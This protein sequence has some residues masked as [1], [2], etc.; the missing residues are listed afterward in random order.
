MIDYNPLNFKIMKQ[1]ILIIGLMIST[2]GLT[3]VITENLFKG[4]SSITLYLFQIINDYRKSNG[5]AQLKLDNAAT[6]SCIHH[7]EFASTYDLSSHDES[8]PG[9]KKDLG[10]L[11]ISHPLDR[12]NH[13]G[14]KMNGG[15]GENC[16]NITGCRQNFEGKPNSEDALKWSAVWKKSIADGKLN[17]KAAAYC[18][19]Y[20]WKYSPG[21]NR[22]MLDPQMKK[23][24]VYMKGYD[25]KDGTP[26]RLCSTFL[27][28]K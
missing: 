5:I 2:K 9:S 4:D 8:V 6:R 12:I 7:T 23:A 17:P 18:I 1:L 15:M 21:H 22:L 16:L 19:F 3:Q 27:S 11:S 13:F 14:I 26:I 25:K 10:L 28:T 20:G 24:S